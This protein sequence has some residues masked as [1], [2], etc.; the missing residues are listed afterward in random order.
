MTSPA[1]PLLAMMSPELLSN[2]YPMT[3]KL[4]A[5]SPVLRTSALFGLDGFLV[6]SHAGCSAVLRSKH[7]GKEGQRVLPPDKLAM[8]P[9]EGV[10]LAEK[11]RHSMLFADP[12]NHTRLRGLV[13]QAFTPRTVERL[14]PRI[15]AITE[16]LL[17]A[18]GDD[19]DLIREVAFPLPIVVIAELLGVPS[20]DKEQF[21]AWSTILTR[22]LDPGATPDELGPIVGALNEL[23]AYLT[24]VIEERRRAPRQ[25]LI[26]DLV[27]AQEAGD[28]LSMPELL[29]TCR[30][31]LTA[32]HETTV[33]LIG[34]GMLALLNHPGERDR[35]IADP[36]LMPGAVEE[37]LRY[38]SPV[39][40]TLRFTFEETV[41]G[42]QT[43]KPGDLVVALLGAAN[44]DPEVFADPDR[45]DVT[46]KNASQHLSL[47][48]GIHYCLGAA[49]ARLE[50]EIA[51]G[52]ILR[53]RPNLALDGTPL[54]WR[55]NVVLRG[56][57]S[58]PV[59]G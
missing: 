50:G 16:E 31:I 18:V 52:A 34:N 11:R 4:R 19:F 58:L 21:K 14:R 1:P 9:Q 20:E 59:R 25:D 27:R 17:D 49:L 43:A 36:S 23:D 8:I 40:M 2:P 38:D 46:R 10:E 32:G 35:L 55:R 22:G 53:R 13:S 42:G 24:G 37:L 3:A 47:G 29:A 28:Q 33:N 45:L 5:V 12:P 41:I 57:T 51:I 39:Q 44:R 7:F 15:A 48:G 6:T 26:S 30:V 54:T 56:V